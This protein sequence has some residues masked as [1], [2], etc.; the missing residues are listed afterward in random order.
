M[1]HQRVTMA[2]LL[3]HT[4]EIHVACMAQAEARCWWAREQ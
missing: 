1:G 3:A 2:K 4:L